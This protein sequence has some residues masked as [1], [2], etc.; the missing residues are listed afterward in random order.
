MSEP[1]DIEQLLVETGAYLEGHFLL[2]SGLHSP[3]YYEKFRF[4][5]D[6]RYNARVAAALAKKFQTREIDV[7]AGAAIGGILL[8]YEVARYFNVRC[9][10]AER[11]DGE[12]AF[13]RGFHIEPKE[14]VLL[15]EDIVTTGGSVMELLELVRETG[16][17]V[18]G[19]GLVVDRSNGRFNPA[20]NWH[21]LYTAAVENYT[22]E[23]C[24]LCEQGIPLTTRGRSGKSR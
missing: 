24:P 9:L 7:I 10:F 15:V 23:E 11:V 18:Q 3:H 13:R 12:L 8:A 16:G 14:K 4:L 19:I 20:E 22:P 21:A 2:T 1:I 17:D 6:P 5:E